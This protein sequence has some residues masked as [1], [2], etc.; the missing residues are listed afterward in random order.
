M[1]VKITA[2]ANCY[3]D[4]CNFFSDKRMRTIFNLQKPVILNPGFRCIKCR[5]RNSVGNQGSSSGYRLYMYADMV[6]DNVFMLKLYP[7]TGKYGRESLTKV[8]VRK[9]IRG[10]GAERR[11]GLLLEHDIRNGLRLM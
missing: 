9:L 7:K 8:E 6:G 11:A 1:L 3:N 4:V 5:I 10:F 2:Y